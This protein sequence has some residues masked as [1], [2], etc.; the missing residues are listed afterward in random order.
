MLVL[1]LV[2][3]VVVVGYMQARKLLNTWQSGS[4]VP[5]VIFDRKQSPIAPMS[6]A[7]RCSLANSRNKELF[8][9]FVPRHGYGLEKG[10]M[11]WVITPLKKG[12]PLAVLWMAG[13]SV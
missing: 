12:R 3:V 11:I 6:Y 7:V 8:T 1:P 10:D 9:V 13:G 5:A 4:A 2:P